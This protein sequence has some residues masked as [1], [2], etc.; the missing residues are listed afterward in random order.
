MQDRIKA[1]LSTS[2]IRRR[3]AATADA[4]LRDGGPVLRSSVTLRALSH[5]AFRRTAAGAAIHHG[6]GATPFGRARIAWSE[7][8]ICRLDFLDATR[9]PRDLLTDPLLSDARWVGDDPG[10]ARLLRRAFAVDPEPGAG[11][12]ALWVAGTEFQVRVWR[13]LLSIPPGGLLS[14]RHVAGLIGQPTSARA[15]GNANAANPVAYLIPC[16]RVLRAGGGIGQYR[17]GAPRM[18]AMVAWEAAGRPAV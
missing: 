6:E 9:S 13:A 12:L 14:Y 17:W 15:V 10:A 8:G 4:L 2:E 11:A 5:E 7:H 16:H 1:P 18:A 3:I